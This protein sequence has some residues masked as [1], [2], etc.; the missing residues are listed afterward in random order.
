MSKAMIS[1]IDSELNSTC[2]GKENKTL[3]FVFDAFSE[4]FTTK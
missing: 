4:D 3:V 1:I 2:T